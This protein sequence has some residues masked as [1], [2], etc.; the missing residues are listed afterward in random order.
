MDTLINLSGGVDSVACAWLLMKDNPSKTFM[1]HHIARTT[2]LGI[3]EKIAVDNS[4]KYFDE[5]GL[6]NYQYKE[7]TGYSTPFS[8]LKAIE[9]VGYFTGL[10]LRSRQEITKVVISANSEDLVQGANYNSRSASRFE[11]VRVVAR[12][13]P[14][15]LWPI[16]DFTKKQLVEMLP[17]GLAA[18]CWS[19]R[20]P[21]NGN[22]CGRC[23]PCRAIIGNRRK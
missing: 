11:I 6:T 15:Y 10:I 17:K 19:C 13:E 4:L 7:T 22:P 5:V 20:K 16:K 9:M 3:Q 1:L 18:A 23:Q 14:E 8:P 2:P 21:K 12:R